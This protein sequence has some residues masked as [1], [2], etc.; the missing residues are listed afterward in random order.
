LDFW[1]IKKIL[2]SLQI[3]FP[4]ITYIPTYYT[5]QALAEK[6]YED[7]FTREDI[8]HATRTK[9]LREE[10]IK[11]VLYYLNLITLASSLLF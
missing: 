1:E 4:A 3:P 7:G 5:D 6:V 10:F 11:L 9:K 8:E 2:S